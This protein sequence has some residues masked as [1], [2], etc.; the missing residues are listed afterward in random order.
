MVV[1]VAIPGFV[2]LVASPYPQLFEPGYELVAQRFGILA[3]SLFADPERGDY[4]RFVFVEG[5]GEVGEGFPAEL[6]RPDM[7]VKSALFID[8]RPASSH[9]PY[10]FLQIGDVLITQDRGDYLSTQVCSD[11]SERGIRHDLPYSIFVVS[12]FPGIVRRRSRNMAHLASDHALDSSCDGS[13]FALHGLKLNSE[14]EFLQFQS[15]LPPLVTEQN[16]CSARNQ[17]VPQTSVEVKRYIAEM[18]RNRVLTWYWGKYTLLGVSPILTKLANH[19]YKRF[20]VALQLV[21]AY[22]GYIGELLDGRRPKTRHLPQGTVVEDHERR[23][24]R[25]L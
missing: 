10:H 3:H 9:R 16:R 17:L 6:L 24:I 18:N 13:P 7:D 2:D 21:L 20:A 4:E 11:V 25:F 14:S 22:S 19:A 8:L 12:Y 23:D 5:L 15:A 1:Q